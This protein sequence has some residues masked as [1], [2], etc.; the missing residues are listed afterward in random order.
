MGEQEMR[1]PKAQTQR[2]GEG[3]RES[4]SER[5]SIRAVFLARRKKLGQ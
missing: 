5:G 3:V 2:K 1:R 4:D